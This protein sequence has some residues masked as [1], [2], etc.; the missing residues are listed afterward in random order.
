MLNLKVEQSEQISM[1]SVEYSIKFRFS[2]YSSFKAGNCLEALFNLVIELVSSATIIIK[3][4]FW[5]VTRNSTERIV[6]K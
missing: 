2:S 5:A 4:P 1:A 6:L 3:G